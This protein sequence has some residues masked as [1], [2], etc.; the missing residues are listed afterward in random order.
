MYYY[1]FQCRLNEKDAKC[2]KI[3][4]ESN[5]SYSFNEILANIENQAAAASDSSNSQGKFNV[6]VMKDYVITLRT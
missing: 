1:R 3:H 6:N 2:F 4:N 5:N